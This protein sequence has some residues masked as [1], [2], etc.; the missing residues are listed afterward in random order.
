MGADGAAAA[1]AIGQAIEA[2][3]SALA[4]VRQAAQEF[5]T[6]TAVLSNRADFTNSLINALGK[7]ASELV[8]ADLN[9]ESANLLALQTRQQLGVAALGL[10]GSGA[11]DILE[12]LL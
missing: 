6:K 2:I 11:S 4:T 8:I 1:G 12:R 3:D 5:G 9:E 10:R 7:G